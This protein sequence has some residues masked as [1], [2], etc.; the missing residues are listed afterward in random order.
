LATDVQIRP[1]AIA[2]DST[3][4]IN[5]GVSIVNCAVDDLRR[6]LQPRLLQEYSMKR[7]T[8]KLLKLNKDTIKKL[9]EHGLKNA[10]GGGSCLPP[11]PAA[12]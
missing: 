6:S 5:A 3:L 12:S 1:N 11:P 8:K 7:D 4:A 10:R 2:P 9:D